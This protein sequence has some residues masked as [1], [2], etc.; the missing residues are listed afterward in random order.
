VSQAASAGRH[1]RELIWPVG[2]MEAHRMRAHDGSRNRPAGNV[3]DGTARWSWAVIDGAVS[4][5]ALWQKTRRWHFDLGTAGGGC[6]HGGAP[7]RMKRLQCSTAW[8]CSVLLTAPCRQ[9]SQV[10][11]TVLA[12]RGLPVHNGEHGSRAEAESGER[13]ERSREG[14]RARRK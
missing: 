13:A 7:R 5:T 11:E 6:P 10:R 4:F 14:A 1:H 12:N 3:G 9:G 2:R 8:A